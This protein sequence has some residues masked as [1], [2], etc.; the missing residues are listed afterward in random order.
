MY[1]NNL[2]AIFSTS[3]CQT[4]VKHPP[5]YDRLPVEVH[6]KIKY[7]LNESLATVV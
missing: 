3:N 6:D 1:I 2:D 5:F 4:W 7:L